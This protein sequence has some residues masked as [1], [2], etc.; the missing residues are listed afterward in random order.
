MMKKLITIT[1]LCAVGVLSVF[2]VNGAEMHNGTFARDEIV[3]KN[4]VPAILGKRTGLNF[5][6][7]YEPSGSESTLPSYYSSKDKNYVLPPQ[8]QKYNDCWAYAATGVFETKLLSQGLAAERLSPLHINYWACSDGNA[9]GWRRSFLDS[10][11]PLIP[12]GYL[13]AWQGPR[14]ESEFPASTNYEDYETV[15]SVSTAKYGVTEI[16]YASGESRETIKQM[17]YDHGAVSGAFS[18]HSQYY[19]ADKTS[20]Y[21]PYELTSGQ[22][23]GHVVS[24]IGWD[25]SYEKENFND[26]YKLPV[27]NGAWLAKNS[28]GNNNSLGGYFWIS[29]EDKHLFDSIFSKSYAISDYME[30]DENVKLYQHEEYGAIYSLDARIQ[31]DRITIMNVYDFSETFRTLDKV[32]FETALKGTGYTVYYIPVTDGVPTADT[33]QWV[34]LYSGTTT[35][36]GYICADLEEYTLPGGKGAIGIAM[37][38]NETASKPYSIGVCEW[39]TNNGKY[40][41]YNDSQYGESYMHYDNT[42]IDIMDYYKTYNK[43]NIGGTPV[44]KAITTRTQ[45]FEIGDVNLDGYVNIVDVTL[46]QRYLADIAKLSETQKTN[47]DF[48]NDGSISIKDATAIQ[49]YLA[50]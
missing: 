43:D 28:M 47:A 39:L 17:I 18:T 5:G 30:I 32:V 24:I 4:P 2:T 27:N 16:K 20:Y 42:I 33:A 3:Y 31:T 19:S 40:V 9:Y 49:R 50:A 46:I 12:M 15:S 13:T 22:L 36:G 6:T 23:N 25:D 41:F 38:K 1:A 14:T 48:N 29:Y 35:F 26:Y 34:E 10:G 8:S 44:I 7:L 37:N 11:Y 21:C 45:Q